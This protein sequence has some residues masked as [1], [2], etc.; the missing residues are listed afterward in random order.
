MDRTV[1][2]LLFLILLSTLVGC[3]SK[4]KIKADIYVEINKDRSGS[5]QLTVL[6]DPLLIPTTKFLQKRLQ[7]QGFTIQSFNQDQKSGWKA[8][9]KV[10]NILQSPS[11]FDEIT[12]LKPTQKKQTTA[13]SDN[14]FF[15]QYLKVHETLMDEGFFW[16]HISIHYDFDLTEIDRELPLQNFSKLFYDR[17]DLD[18]HL[19]LPL[20]PEQHNAVQVSKD[21]KTFTWP[22]K[23]GEHNSL[24]LS[25]DVPN[26]LGW[27][28]CGIVFLLLIIALSVVMYRKKRQSSHKPAD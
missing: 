22:L 9:K 5:Y 17:V 1:R 11:A 8:Q 15:Q 25:I 27:N 20:E 2:L 3:S 7:E 14:Q 24:I 21:G 6:G 16:K 10:K 23:L 4:Q 12:T 19:T 28:V 26:P 13:Q 18:F